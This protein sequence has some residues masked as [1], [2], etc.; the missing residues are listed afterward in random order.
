MV[1]IDLVRVPGSGAWIFD[2]PTY[3]LWKRESHSPLLWISGN[4]GVGK[5]ILSSAIIKDLQSR[6]RDQHQHQG[7]VV[8][9]FHCRS[10]QESS[11]TTLGL[12]A[13]LIMQL[14]A[15]VTAEAATAA[16]EA[17]PVHTDIPPCL[18][19]AY[20]KSIKFGR[21]SMSR[22]DGPENILQSLASR[23]QRVSVVVDGLDEMEEPDKASEILL[24]LS[25]SS[26]TALSIVFLSRNVPP[27][28]KRLQS[29][30]Q[31]HISA[32][33]VNRD[34][35]SYAQHRSGDL[36]LDRGEVRES[37]V[38]KVC[39]KADGMFLWAKMI[40]D[41]MALAVS[42]AHLESILD[43]CPSG[44][45][46]MYGH[47]LQILNTRSDEVQRLARDI[48]RWVVY[49]SRPLT[50]DELEAAL[51][52]GTRSEDSLEMDDRTR[53]FRSVITELCSP[54]IVVSTG[55]GGIVR[56]VHH[57]I[58]E[59]LT[60][61]PS[62]L[63]PSGPSSS[64]LNGLEDAHTELALRCLDYL[65]GRFPHKPSTAKPAFYDYSLTSWCHHAVSG[66]Y[67]AELDAK[68][69][70]I[71]GSP[72]RRQA[73]LHHL[74]FGDSTHPFPFQKIFQQQR[75]LAEWSK[76]RAQAS[77]SSDT[78][79]VP[80]LSLSVSETDWCLDALELLL[81]L[82]CHA[83]CEAKH[84]SDKAVAPY[85]VEIS[86]FEKMMLVRALARQLTRTGGLGVALAK[87]EAR[88]ASRTE[89]DS[90]TPW[91]AALLL[92]TIGVLYDQQ[93][94]GD[95]SLQMHE[96]ALRLQDG[97]ANSTNMRPGGGEGSALRSDLSPEAV[98]T[99]NELGRMH[100]HL[101][102]YA[103]AEKMHRTA[104]AVLTRTQPEDHPERVWTVN[105]LATALRMGGHPA[106]ALPLHLAAYKARSDSLGPLHAHTLWSAGDVA[107]CHRDM[108][109][110]ADAEIWFRRALEGR[111]AQLGHSH[112][113]TLWSMNQL[114]LVLADMGRLSEARGMHAKALEGQVQV[115]GSEHEHSR[116]S[117][118]AVHSLSSSR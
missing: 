75:H 101:G 33:D 13:T 40:M 97:R 78:V 60:A 54:F 2:H 39:L 41:D 1:D 24:R 83:R 116:W 4:P 105:T 12:L 109:A 103:E 72:S 58:R 69:A 44:L 76:G 19:E 68:M 91:M 21:R 102:H 73:W 87:L 67:R 111:R 3:Q 42:I 8:T 85:I 94:R 53:P 65:N 11:R 37:M 15:V 66:P 118:H 7:H 52:I 29:Q 114:G 88:M 86:Y 81:L 100:R 22:A 95:L 26:S 80:L 104:L 79:T 27:I 49:A 55:G 117:S 51:T 99:I 18:L 20:Q 82:P 98:W 34:I 56:P 38:E 16:S 48:M 43:R 113:D 89:S 84:T 5:T 90:Q 6:A 108:G 31:I 47:F 74:F 93:A 10:D 96:K 70:R 112:P 35:W 106:E 14:G 110:L 28:K 64:H 32:Q 59:Y 107:K 9:Y 92:N 57:S 62:R 46:A 25:H 77:S 30:P 23:F 63:A 36:P 45:Y 71:I 61:E 115:L 17:A 50:V